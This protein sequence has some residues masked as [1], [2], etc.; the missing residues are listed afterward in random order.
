MSAQ[1]IRATM[2]NSHNTNT[3]V[4]EH[5]P[6]CGMVIPR[7]CAKRLI[8]LSSLVHCCSALRSTV[9][10]CSSA[11]RAGERKTSGSYDEPANPPAVQ[12][13]QSTNPVVLWHRAAVPQN[14]FAERTLDRMRYG[15]KPIARQYADE[16]F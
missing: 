13:E 15:R 9:A 1:K 10:T 8:H 6:F 16:S 7:A 5:F 2:A 4:P 14:P 12:S 11:A 3:G